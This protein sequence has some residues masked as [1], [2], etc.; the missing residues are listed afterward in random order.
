MH[1]NFAGMKK[2]KLTGCQKNLFFLLT[3]VCRHVI[4]KSS[5]IPSLLSA[6]SFCRREFFYI[7]L[8]S[9]FIDEYRKTNY[10]N[11]RTREPCSAEK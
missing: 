1:G 10:K 9:Y 7:F 6:G 4:I 5:N 2:F 11:S 3:T 8:I